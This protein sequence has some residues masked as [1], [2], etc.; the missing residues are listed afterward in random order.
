MTSGR[1][2]KPGVATVAVV[3]LAL[4]AGV[5]A[6]RWSAAL[7]IPLVMSV[8]VAIALDP[9]VRQLERLRLPR[10]LAAGL[11]LGGLVAAIVGGS[12]MLR[13]EVAGAVQ[14]L[15]EATETIR[16]ELRRL[17]GDE[18]SALDALGKAADT[19]EAAASEAA[20]TEA[21]LPSS[22]TMDIGLRE[23]VFV[24]S[25]SIVGWAGQ[26]LLLVFLV[27]FL[28]ASDDLFKRKFVRLAGPAIGARRITVSM[29]DGIHRSLERFI[30]VTLGMN[31]VVAVA[32]F[33]A[34]SIYGLAYAPLWAVVGGALNTIPYVGSAIAVAMFTLAA[35]V[36]F[37]NINDALAIGGIFLLISS[38]EG[39]VLK[40]WVIGRAARMNNVAVFAGL[41]FWGWLW[42]AWG[43][44]LAYPIM[45]VGKIIA[46]HVESLH[47]VAEL[48]DG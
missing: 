8:L 35:Q 7:L 26:V 2:A 20:G 37:G 27:F 15:P 40:P 19:I 42:G 48:L 1:T 4:V 41:L 36:Q 44:L 17:R 45:M 21:R 18:P 6:L 9:F 38:V 22:Q 11:V 39:M 24:G 14:Q 34:F 29:L 43:M 31:A 23:W 16:R 5:W 47:P 13:D 12:W 3:V 28:L 25:M 33:A 46:D 32:T 10:A 30:L